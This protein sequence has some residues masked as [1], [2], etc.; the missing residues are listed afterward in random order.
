MD[1]ASSYANV[2]GAY[3]WLKQYDKAEAFLQQALAIRKQLYGNSHASVGS[4]Y[5]NLAQLMERQQRWA[6]ALDYHQK[7]Y[8]IYVKVYK[9]DD[10]RLLK[11]QESIDELKQKLEQD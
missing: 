2:A 1:V 8:D 11:T 7:A 10:R 5:N 3:M 9:P 6:E 4:Y